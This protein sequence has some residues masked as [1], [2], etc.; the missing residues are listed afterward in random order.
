MADAQRSMDIAKERG[1]SLKQILP[2][3]WISSSPL[4]DGYLPAHVNKSKLIGE[5][6]SRPDISKWSRE[7]LLPTHVIVDFMSKMRQM[8]DAQF[9]TL[10]GAINAVINLASSICQGPEY[11]HLVLDSYVKMSFKECERLRRGDEATGI[12][13]IDI[14]RDIPIPQQLNTFWASK[15]S[16]RNLHLL[17]R[18]I[19]CNNVCANPIIASSVVSDNEA[20]PAIKFGNEV[21]SELL[22][23]IQEVNAR[24]VAPVDWAARIKQCQRVVVKSNDSESFA[25]LLHFRNSV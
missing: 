19:V 7:S 3:D 10:G 23:W 5:I 1:M 2:H 25:L 13:I 22:N 14:S 24:V 9:S 18:Y 17:V 16:K 12:A 8:P 4:V 15:E 11:I 6:E 20:L 21:I